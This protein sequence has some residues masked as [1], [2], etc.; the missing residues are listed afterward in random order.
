M[1]ENTTL[2]SCG[3]CRHWKPANHSHLC[4][5]GTCF[6]DFPMGIPRNRDCYCEKHNAING[7]FEDKGE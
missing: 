7:E 6:K 5:E 2:K 1:S 3:D 4:Y